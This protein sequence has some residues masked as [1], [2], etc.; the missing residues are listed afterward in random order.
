M[1]DKYMKVAVNNANVDQDLLV[2]FFQ[3]SSQMKNTH[4]D[5]SSYF[6]SHPLDSAMYRSLIKECSTSSLKG[7]K[8]DNCIAACATN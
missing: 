4:K 5:N 3:L 8:I 7:T 2:K 1:T 6:I